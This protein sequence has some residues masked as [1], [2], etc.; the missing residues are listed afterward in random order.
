M[1]LQLSQIFLTLGCTF[2]TN[3]LVRRTLGLTNERGR[4]GLLVSVNDPATS[5]VVR[6]KFHHHT[7]L[8]EDPNVVLAHLA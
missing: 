3:F 8:R 2:I 5:E 1:T 7:V 4:V 6:A